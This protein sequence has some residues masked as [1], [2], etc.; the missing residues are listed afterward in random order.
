ML[1]RDAR[2]FVLCCVVWC[3]VVWWCAVRRGV[4]WCVVLGGV[5]VRW[6]GLVWGEVAL[7][8]GGGVRCCGV[9]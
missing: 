3:G 6:V 4:V 1:C 7:G 5:S 8:V 2:C 9:G